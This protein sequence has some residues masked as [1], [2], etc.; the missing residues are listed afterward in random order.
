MVEFNDREA[1]V[2]DEIMAVLKKHPVFENFWLTNETVLSLPGLE[3]YSC[4]KRCLEVN[5]PHRH[6]NPLEAKSKGSEISCVYSLFIKNPS[7]EL[8]F[9]RFSVYN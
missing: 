1:G 3:I 7:R 9:I 4:E 6:L 2:F 5:P 8:D